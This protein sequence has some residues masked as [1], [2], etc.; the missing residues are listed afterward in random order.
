MASP[1]IQIT[2]DE[3][4]TEDTTDVS[5]RLIRKLSIPP[6]EPTHKRTREDNAEDEPAAK[7][8]RTEPF[9]PTFLVMKV[10]H[11]L[12]LEQIVEMYEAADKQIPV[13]TL[14]LLLKDKLTFPTQVDK[15][16]TG[17]GMSFTVGKYR[18]EYEE[19]GESCVDGTFA[20]SFTDYNT[21]FYDGDHR[22]YMHNFRKASKQRLNFALPFGGL[23]VN[24]SEA[25]IERSMGEY[26][27]T[28]PMPEVNTA[29]GSVAS[30][31]NAASGRPRRFSP[32]AIRP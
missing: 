22:F 32:F 4:P 7:R 1:S 6:E 31:S 30:S 14:S 2:T 8:S 12:P 25:D 20:H 3:H 24:E 9:L 10:I 15:Y 23:G 19:R 28:Y 17:V 16:L 11:K 5:K 21:S 27:A 29:T 18:V 26:S 13:K